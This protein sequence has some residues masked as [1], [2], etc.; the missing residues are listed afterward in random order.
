MADLLDQLV[1]WLRIPSISTGGGDPQDLRR[2]AEWAAGHVRR[3]GG[4]AELVQI[5]GGNPLVVGDLRAARAGAPTVL[6]YGHY[7]V[8]GPGS[9]AAWTSPPF[10]P[11]VRDGRLYAR[12]AADDKGNFWPL[13]YVACELA[14]AG[15][16]PVDVRVVVEGE[17]EAGSGSVAEWIRGD[18]RGAD[19]AI[20]FDSGMVDERTPAITVGLRGMLMAQIEVRTG[21]R[22]VHSGIYGGSVLNALH[23]LHA[24][25]AEVVPGADGR[26]REELRAG[27]AAPAQAERDS[28]TRLPPGEQVLAEVGGR[29]AYPGAADEYY[30]RNGADAALDVNEVVGG[31]P[32]TLVP[33]AAC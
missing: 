9:L 5:G 24:M 18:E 22:D 32:R 8:Q 1:D 15:E 23:V 31:E 13:L 27:I 21:V 26:L 30:E 33:A 19:A 7:D 16:L 11:E 20:V 14:A 12:G 29:P 2:A 17:E 4:E 25:L 3:A 28:W 10:E 6:I